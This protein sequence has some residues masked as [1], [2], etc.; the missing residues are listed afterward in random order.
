M[1]II[2]KLCVMRSTVNVNEL[3]TITHYVLSH[4][5]TTKYF[6]ESERNLMIAM[7]F[8]DLI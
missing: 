4:E 7:Q 1:V 2:P 6:F 3:P 5:S 8:N